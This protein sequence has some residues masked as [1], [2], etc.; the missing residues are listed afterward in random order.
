[1][2]DQ[3]SPRQKAGSVGVVSVALL[4]AGFWTGQGARPST[5]IKV[6]TSPPA[7]VPLSATRPGQP[8]QLTVHVSGAVRAP[9]VYLLRLGS[10]VTD[11]VR[12]AGGWA[13]GADPDG[14]NLAAPVFDGMK[15]DVPTVGSVPDQ[16]VGEPSSIEEGERVSLNNGSQADLERLPGIGPALASRIIEY[17]VAHGGFHTIDELLEVEG[18]GE[19][20]FKELESKV[21]L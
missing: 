19:A 3:M 1:M 5:P 21:S 7:Q 15:V 2:W 11:A 12:A 4:S 10:R 20:T 9:G 6:V 16:P 14:L 8:T 17:R 13:P 18:I